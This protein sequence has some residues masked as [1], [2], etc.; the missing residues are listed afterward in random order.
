VHTDDDGNYTLETVKPAAYP[1]GSGSFRPADTHFEMFGK[2]EPQVTQSLYTSKMA[3]LGRRFW[4][5]IP[6][7]GTH[8][9]NRPGCRWSSF[10]HC[11]RCTASRCG[12]TKQK[13]LALNSQPVRLSLPPQG[14]GTRRW[15]VGLLPFPAVD[16]VAV[17]NHTDNGNHG[18]YH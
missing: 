8:T 9:L 6:R 5:P 10:G 12:A 14:F 11:A 18:K 2:P 16:Q 13:P 17:P 15:R 1:A 7:T 3:F 4:L